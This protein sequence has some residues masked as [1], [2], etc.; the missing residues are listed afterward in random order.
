MAKEKVALIT[1][2]SS[3][4]GEASAK[5]LVNNGHKVILTARS[6]D[7][8]A[9]LVESLGE[10][11]ALSVPADA[12]DFT[13]LENVVTKG[14][15]KFGRLDAAFANAGMGVSTAGTE[16]GDPDEWSTMIDINIKALLWTAKATLPHLRQNKGHF[17]LTSSAAGR[18]PIKG[19]IYGA[20]KWFAYGF[21]QNLAEEMSEWNG[22]CTTIAP[23]MVNT[24]F[25]DE[26]KP[27]KLD[28]QDV[29]DAVL[30]AIEANQ[31]NNVR[32]IYLMPTN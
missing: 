12:T 22:R 1:G 31:R 7:K 30:F 23:G 16:K 29:A 32:E 6:E 28:P 27:D 15:K 10:D 20:T 4:I 11:N 5:T 2:A 14:L 19:S 25:F 21:G 8:L 9:E 13:E 18:K 24:P 3:G 17:I 26:A